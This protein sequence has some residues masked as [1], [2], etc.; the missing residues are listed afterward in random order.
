MQSSLWRSCGVPGA[1]MAPSA[2]NK[3]LGIA[4]LLPVSP[5][6]QATQSAVTAA[7]QTLRRTLQ[8]FDNWVAEGLAFDEHLGRVQK[9]GVEVGVEQ[10]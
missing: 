8:G 10:R 3:W 4:S 7:V 1:Y 9:V 2:L 6:A 5:D